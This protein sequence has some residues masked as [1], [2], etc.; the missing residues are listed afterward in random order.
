MYT[1]KAESSQLI[2]HSTLTFE[3]FLYVN[4]FGH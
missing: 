1:F 3:R 2:D 4:S